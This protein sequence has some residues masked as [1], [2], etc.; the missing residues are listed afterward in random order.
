MDWYRRYHGTCAD[1]KFRLVA[2]SAGVPTPF[3]I[4]AW[5]AV[6]EHASGHV[7]RGSTDGLTAELLAITIDIAEEQAAAILA[8]F[9]KRGMVLD[10]KVA[11]WERRQKSSDASAER[12]RRY[13]DRQRAKAN[14]P[15]TE[16]DVTVCDVTASVTNNACDVTDACDVTAVT[17]PSEPPSSPLKLPPI[18]PRD[19][20]RTDKPP[21]AHPGYA[22]KGTVIR[23]SREHFDNW[24]ESAPDIDLPAWLMSRDAWLAGQ[25]VG[26]SIRKSWFLS[27]A[28]KLA[29]DQKLAR[30]ERLKSSGGR[31]ASSAAG[32]KFTEAQRLK[33]ARARAQAEG[34][35]PY[36][37][38][39]EARVWAIVREIAD[40]EQRRTA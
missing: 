32:T 22:W 6:L 21:A 28:N 40:G 25:P 39:N 7:D 34:L 20:N 38:E 24:T 19:Q 31:H 18:S 29:A 5:D 1:P 13:R 16:H 35:N 17:E 11:A 33:Q 9:E 30:A 23:L 2:R 27:T 4:C 14:D 3:V 8:Q 15:A 10:G 26:S 36:D 12:T 37:P